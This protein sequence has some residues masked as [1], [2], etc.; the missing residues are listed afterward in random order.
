M[1]EIVQ[2]KMKYLKPNIEFQTY[3]FVKSQEIKFDFWGMTFSVQPSS[4]N[5][6]IPRAASNNGFEI[7]P[8]PILNPAAGMVVSFTGVSW[9]VLLQEYPFSAGVTE[10]VLDSCSRCQAW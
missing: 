8:T 10:E 2:F 5:P 4:S 9:A 3:Y 7:W 1:K 6:V